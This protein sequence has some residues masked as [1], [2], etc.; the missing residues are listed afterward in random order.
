MNQ[1]LLQPSFYHSSIFV[2]I[3]LFCISFLFLRKY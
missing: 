3:L 2:Y 1:L